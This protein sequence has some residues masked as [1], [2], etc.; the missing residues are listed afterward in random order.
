M[1]R[2]T[3]R[4]F[5]QGS[6]L[7]HTFFADVC[8][9]GLPGIDWEYALVHLH[10]DLRRNYGEDYLEK[11]V[12]HPISQTLDLAYGYHCTAR[13]ARHVGDDELADHLDELA[14][15]WTNAF[16]PATGLLVDSDLLRGR[17]VE[18]LVPPAAR[19]GRADRAGRRRRRL[20]R[21]ARPLLRLRRSRRSS[22]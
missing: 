10:D 5:R 18:L 19:H 14:E 13:V 7:A 6:A 21:H 15:R 11:G 22:S 2:G 16:D 9:L 12:A 1:A 8:A 3:D 4:F 20:R 17:A